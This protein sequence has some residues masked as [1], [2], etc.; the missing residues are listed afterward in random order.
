MPKQDDIDIYGYGLYR[1][2]TDSIGYMEIRMR[3]RIHNEND[4]ED[5]ILFEK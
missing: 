3:V 5:P 4:D 2:S 1:H